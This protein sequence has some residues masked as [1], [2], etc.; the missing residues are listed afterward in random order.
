MLDLLDAADH[1]DALSRDVPL[2]PEDA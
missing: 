2:Q 1:I